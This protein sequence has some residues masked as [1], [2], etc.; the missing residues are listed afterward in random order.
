MKSKNIIQIHK[1][2]SALSLYD[3]VSL[4]R[5]RLLHP[6]YNHKLFTNEEA[7]EYVYKIIQDKRDLYDALPFGA[8]FDIRRGAV[9]YALGGLY[10]DTDMYPV[11][12]L[13]ETLDQESEDGLFVFSSREQKMF[14]AG[15]F[16]AEQGHP[17]MKEFV[18][19]SIQR[20]YERPQPKE[21]DEISWA[22]W[23]LYATVHLWDDLFKSTGRK[24]EDGISGVDCHGHDLDDRIK[25]GEVPLAIHYSTA[26]WRPENK[27]KTGQDFYDA[28]NGMLSRI[29]ELYGHLL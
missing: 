15:F 2:Y 22:G 3:K 27:D 25:T 24:F 19:Q 18:L 13:E 7:D 23:L 16:A 29:Q 14:M 26:L 10:S 6:S 9:V 1:G 12:S 8:K 11:V 21:E 28:Q 17:L 4:E 5:W 20:F